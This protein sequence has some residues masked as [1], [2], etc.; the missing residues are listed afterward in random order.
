MSSIDA[1]AE[2]ARI[3][4]AAAARR[5]AELAAKRAAEL[6]AKKAAEAAE[7]KAAEAAAKRAA[8]AAAK[9]AA[10]VRAKKFGKDEQSTGVGSALKTRALKISGGADVAPQVA[11]DV[12]KFKASDLA[13]TGG[14]DV[15]VKAAAREGLAK[16]GLNADDVKK[17]GEKIPQNLTDAADKIGKGDVKGAIKSLADEAANHPDAVAKAIQF[18][19]KQL[20]DGFAKTVFS[21]PKFAAEIARKGPE[22]IKTALDD[23]FEAVKAAAGD[24]KLRDTA[25]DAAMSDEKFKGAIDKLGLTAAE[26]KSAGDALPSVI[27]AAQKA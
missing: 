13:R 8:A 25:I 9:Q 1:A 17:L 7:K 18:S 21:D 11:A 19:A 6:A 4:A 12:Q 20:P 24:K 10:A 15:N 3:A 22:A 16:L 27:D 26:L 23:P 5:A 14:K 2:A